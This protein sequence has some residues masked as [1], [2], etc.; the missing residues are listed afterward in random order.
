MAPA[1]HRWF[2]GLVSSAN[3]LVVLDGLVLVPGLI[4]TV[5]WLCGC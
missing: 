5:S 1:G 2:E 4:V 3:V